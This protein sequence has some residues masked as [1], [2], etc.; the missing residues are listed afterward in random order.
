[1]DCVKLLFCTGHVRA[2]YTPIAKNSFSLPK[3][4][5]NLIWRH[6]LVF[7]VPLLKFFLEKGWGLGRGKPLYIIATGS[8]KPRSANETRTTI[9]VSESE[10][11]TGRSPKRHLVAPQKRVFPSQK[12][13]KT[14]TL[15][16]SSHLLVF[17]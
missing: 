8:G 15:S 12:K 4:K 14:I 3:F 9:L 5:I 13:T 11:A 2:M 7:T 16:Q 1:M 10:W 17:H 6:T